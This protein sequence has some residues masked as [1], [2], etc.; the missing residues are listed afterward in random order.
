MPAGTALRH[1]RLIRFGVPLLFFGCYFVFLLRYIDPAVI[2]SS[3]G[4]NIH[5]YVAAMHAQ[6]DSPKHTTYYEDPPYRHPF[7]LELTPEYLRETV[8]TPG[9]WTRFAVTLCIYACHYPFA[10]ALAVTALALFFFWIFPRYIQG[11]G[12]RRPF[13]IGFVPALFL[14]TL[15]AWYELKYCAYLLPVAGALA[16]AVIY[17]RFRPTGPLARALFLSLLFWIAWYF[18]Q[19]GCLLVL[20]FAIIHEFYCPERK[21]SFILIA[22]A[23]NGALLYALNAWFIPLDM[24]IRWLDFTVLSGLPLAVIGFFPLSAIILAAW[25]RFRRTPAGEAT[26]KGTIV[27]TSLL[28]CGAIVSA[29]WLCKD[30]VNRDTRTFARTIYHVTNGQ[31]EAILHEKTDSIFEDFPKKG[32]ALQA[33]MVHAVDHAL[34]RTGQIGDRLFTFPQ[35]V[36]AYDPLLML[37][38]TLTGGYV[39]WVVVLELAMDLGMVNTAEKIAGEIMENMGPFPD[40]IYRRAL[41]Q[42]AKGNRDAAAVYLGK[43]TCMPF[44]RAEAKRLLHLL[45]NNDAFTSEPRIAAMRAY[46]DATDYFL[47]T[48]SYDAMLKRLLQSNPGNKMAYDYLMTFCIYNGQLDGLA[49]LAPA[50]PAF[51]Y[52][53]LPRCWEEALY[54]NMAANAEQAPSEAFFSGL[55]QETMARFNGFVRACLPL[56]NDSIAAAALAPAFGDS[57]F[58]FSIFRYS[59]GVLHE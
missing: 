19:W 36:F 18:F 35:K 32:G 38:N 12:T 40:I 54:V 9:G 44:Y 15:C 56:G 13:V 11:F 34:C 50:A 49:T 33:F 2:Y 46:M 20:L 43:L 27:W 37:Q 6:N 59:R 29:M 21:I 26:V 42:I 5:N 28:A 7:I 22:A 31:W 58:Y 16:F 41:I 3:N 47:F 45:D 17:Q 51:G 57:Y 30:P 8:V 39:H 52:A 1:D 14:M 4:I 25:S 55:R 10:G 23:V 24:T 53:V 48:V